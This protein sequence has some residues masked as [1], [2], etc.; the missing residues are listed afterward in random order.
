MI[1]TLHDAR[2]VALDFPYSPATVA[3][4]KG[5]PGATWDKESKAWYAPLC[6]LRRLVDAFP[7]ATIDQAAPNCRRTHETTPRRPGG[8]KINART[9]VEKV[10]GNGVDFQ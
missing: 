4:V 3:R 1:I 6:H 9:G 5:F 8:R 2:T 10:G 7:G